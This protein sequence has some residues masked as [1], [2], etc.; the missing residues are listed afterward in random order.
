M[1]WL[2]TFGSAVVPKWV[3]ER[4]NDFEDVEDAL[5]RLPS[6]G[7]CIAEDRSPHVEQWLATA[8]A[9]VFAY[10]WEVYSGPYK[11][12]SIPSEPL[13]VEALPR[14]L[15]SIAL[16]TRFAGLCF[17]DRPVLQLQDVLACRRGDV[18]TIE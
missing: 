4:S 15:A 9:G 3:E 16:R 10:D 6:R 17:R 11:V 5:A 8:R 13:K 18:P 7:E 2:V 1:A 14:D 12:L